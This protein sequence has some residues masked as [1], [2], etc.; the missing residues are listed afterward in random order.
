MPIDFIDAHVHAHSRSGEDFGRLRLA[1]CA[2]LL[3]VADEGGGYSGPGS[4]LDHFKRLDRVDRG[5]VELAGLKFHLAL[6]MHPR[7]IPYGG[8]DEVLKAMPEALKAYRAAAVGEIGLELGGEAE[9][10]MLAEQ[11]NIAAQVGLPAIVHTPRQDKRRAVERIL[12]LLPGCKQQ[13]ENILL[14]HLDEEVLPMVADTGCFLGLS[15]HPAK[16][17]PDQAAGLVEAHGSG[18]F[19]LSTDMGAAASWLFGIPA[20]ISAM[21]DRGLGDDVIRAVVYDNAAGL[22]GP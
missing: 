12:A 22:L 20:A 11:L 13:P 4:V 14:D 17:S 7:G 9:E 19:I 6:G 10:R 1:G 18:R 5:R 3:A 16:L 8:A 2:G 21:Q 15:I